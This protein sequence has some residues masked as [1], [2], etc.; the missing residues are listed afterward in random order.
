MFFFLQKNRKGA[1]YILL[2]F[3]MAWLLMACNNDNHGPSNP[4]IEKEIQE[5]AVDTLPD[6]LFK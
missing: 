4:N 5:K 2:L 6:T 3:V 1:T